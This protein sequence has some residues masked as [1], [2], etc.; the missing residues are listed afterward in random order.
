VV[1]AIAGMAIVDRDPRSGVFLPFR[2][3]GRVMTRLNLGAGASKDPGYINVDRQAIAEPDQ[4]HDLNL[5]PYPFATS[6]ID[7]VR[8]FHI[9]E[10][11][12]RPFEVMREVHR[13]LKPGGVLHMKVPHFSRAF[14]HAE[15]AHGFDITFPLYFNPRFTRSG[16]FGVHYRLDWLR[17]RWFAFPELLI[18]LGYSRALVTLLCGISAAISAIG[19]LSPPL[20]SRLWC[21]WVGGFDEIEMRFVCVK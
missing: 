21:F 2:W 16:Y 13:I 19:N 6:S 17:L 4:V 20:A 14:T 3:Q 5:F 11:L 1:D 10:H 18:G 7:E 15:H 9:V 8:A 12:D